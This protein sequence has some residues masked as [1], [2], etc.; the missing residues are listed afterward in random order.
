MEKIGKWQVLQVYARLCEINMIL[1]GPAGNDDIL[2]TTIQT[3]R[4]YMYLVEIKH[5][6]HSQYSLKNTFLIYMI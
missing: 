1:G 6:R 5:R 4:K 2:N 3:N